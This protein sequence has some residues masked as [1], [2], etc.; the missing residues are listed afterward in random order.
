MPTSAEKSQ[1]VARN[2]TAVTILIRYEHI[3]LQALEELGPIEVPE[4]SEQAR[5]LQGDL[6]STLGDVLYRLTIEHG[7][8]FAPFRETVISILAGPEPAS[9]AAFGKS[10]PRP[11]AAAFETEH[12]LV[13]LALEMMPAEAADY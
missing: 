10:S 2:K 4:S 5:E 7:V 12:P 9:V 13:L 11:F 3:I 6:A 1:R 8:P